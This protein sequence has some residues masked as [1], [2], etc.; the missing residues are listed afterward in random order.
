[1]KITFTDADKTAVKEYIMLMLGAPVVQIELDDKH[2]TFAVNEA[3]ARVT[4]QAGT[5]PPGEVAGHHQT[6]CVFLVEEG[7]LAYAK[8]IL[9][10]IRSKFHGAMIGALQPSD[11]ESLLREG[12]NELGMWKSDLENTQFF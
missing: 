7:A 8:L 1:M 6:N 5:Q 2:L 10:R 12:E 11:G 3:L 9:G 4:Y